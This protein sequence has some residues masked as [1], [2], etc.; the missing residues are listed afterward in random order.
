[1]LLL[2]LVPAVVRVLTLAL[3]VVQALLLVLVLALVPVVLLV[4][5]PEGS[6]KLWGALE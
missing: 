6:R 2:A 1:M 3:A 4:L 5:R